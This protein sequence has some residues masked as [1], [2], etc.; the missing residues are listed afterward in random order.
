M[1]KKR[2]STI[3]YDLVIKDDRMTGEF[4]TTAGD[5]KGSV[6]WQRDKS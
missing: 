5:S 1:E 2:D 4:F 6:D 3:Y